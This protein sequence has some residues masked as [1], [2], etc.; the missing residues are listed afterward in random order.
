MQEITPERT[1]IAIIGAGIAGMTLAAL[2][3][4]SEFKPIVHLFER[5]QRNRDQGAGFDIKG[6]G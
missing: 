1:K 3:R 6:K 2:L 4:H 5:D